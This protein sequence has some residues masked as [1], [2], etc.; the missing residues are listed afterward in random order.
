M[1]ITEQTG[2][3]IKSNSVPLTDLI[4]GGT[5]SV[6]AF[7]RGDDTWA[8]LPS[9]GTLV[10]N[11]QTVAAY[12]LVLADDNKDV[13]IS[14]ASANTV[15]VPTNATVAFSIGSQIIVTWFG[16]GQTTIVAATGVTIN[17]TDTLKL[18]KRYS[19]ILLEKVATDTW[20]LSG[21]TEVVSGGA[22][23]IS[24][25]GA[26]GTTPNANAATV[27]SGVLTLQPADGT[28]PGILSAVGQYVGGFKGFLDVI[29]TDKYM[30]FKEQASA[31]VDV[32]ANYGQIWVSSVGDLMFQNDSLVT[33]NIS[34]PTGGGGANALGTYLVQTATNSPANAQ[35]MGVLGTG[36]VKNTTT[37]GVQSIA[38]ADTDYLT[39][40]G[41]AAALTGFPTFNQNTTGTSANVTGIVLGAN[42]GTGIANNG[43]TI[44]LGGN[45]S[46]SGAF[47]TILTVTAATS[48]TLPV[49]GTLATIADLVTKENALGNPSTDGYVLSS[50][51]AGARSWVAQGGAGVGANA[52]GTYLVQAALNAP[53]NAQVMGS[54]GTGLVK[55][56]TTTGVQTIAVAGIDYATSDDV[57]AKVVTDANSTYTDQKN[58]GGNVTWLLLFNATTSQSVTGRLTGYRSGTNNAQRLQDYNTLQ[59][60]SRLWNNTT[61]SWGYWGLY[62]DTMD[63]TAKGQT[64]FSSD[65]NLAGVL[66]IGANNTVLTADSTQPLGVKWATTENFVALTAAYTLTSQTAAQKLFN[67]SAT[68]AVAVTAATSYFFECQFSLTAMSATSG[69]FGF[70]FGGTATL[71]SQGWS[72]VVTK[73]T[74]NTTA[75]AASATYNIAANTT[76]I[77][78]NTSTTGLVKIQGTI[79]INAAGTIIPQVS[80]TVAAAAI[81]GVNSFFRMRP[82]GSNT[83]TTV[84]TWT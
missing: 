13:Q 78:A 84:G 22:N 47:P 72:A 62:L 70:A 3:G 32:G 36:L 42:G 31:P 58:Y 10:I 44:T 80:L 51:T 15:T 34:S 20:D 26:V 54:L 59:T 16:V 68:G 40:T 57:S 28:T 19:K 33:K 21:D 14:N 81:V 38:V 30:Q 49:S 24:S 8:V 43:K 74:A 82:I 76:L 46:T 41:N 48:I 7:I 6:N 71:T 39:P 11:P 67:A 60:Y 1:A 56:T 4:I 69:S 83:V 37:T 5:K 53:T 12:T 2:A 63:F 77:L 45:L 35:V 50:T 55:N 17:Y 52:L 65:V 61:T 18:R 79:R 27:T 73:G 23:F 25:L 75:A 29:S 64:Y 66:A 9:S